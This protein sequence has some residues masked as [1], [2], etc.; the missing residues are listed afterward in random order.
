MKR[1]AGQVPDDRGNGNDAGF[2]G[3]LDFQAEV[4][5]FFRS[6]GDGNGEEVGSG[7]KNLFF[8]GK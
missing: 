2:A 4:F 5:C 3:D 6:A 1:V 8:G 7:F